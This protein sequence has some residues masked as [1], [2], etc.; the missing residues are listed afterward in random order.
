VVLP[1]PMPP[2]S[3]G[4]LSCYAEVKPRIPS[5]PAQG[6]DERISKDRPGSKPPTGAAL[7]GFLGKFTSALSAAET[8]SMP[9]ASRA[10]VR[11]VGRSGEVIIPTFDKPA[12]LE[13]PTHI[14]NKPPTP[15]DLRG[16]EV[17]TPE[18]LFAPTP[19]P[20][21]TSRRIEEQASHRDLLDDAFLRD[22]GL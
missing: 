16:I 22:V 21:R 19:K 10:D 14:A 5:I 1:E 12:H 9:C 18:D 4:T 11:P 13:Q 17:A 20:R 3:G 7:R 15:T 8:E 2:L 6:R